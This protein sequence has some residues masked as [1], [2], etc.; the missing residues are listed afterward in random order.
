MRVDLFVV[1]FLV[2]LDCRLPRPSGGTEIE[3]K[4]TNMAPIKFELGLRADINKTPLPDESFNMK[5]LIT[6]NLA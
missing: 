6:H 2:C 5:N 3:P 4:R 1:A